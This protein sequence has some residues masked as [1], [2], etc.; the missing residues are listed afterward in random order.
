M[1]K[2]N[3]LTLTICAVILSVISQ[4][5]YAQTGAFKITAD[6]GAAHDEFGNS[7]SVSGDYFVVGARGD[8]DNGIFSGSVYVFKRSGS[9]WAQ[10]TKLFPLKEDGSSDAE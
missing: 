5:A 8:D 1:L 3:L 4:A 7:V 9:G 10:Q 2:K 6:D